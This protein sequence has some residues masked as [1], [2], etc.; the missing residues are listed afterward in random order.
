M[1]SC[2]TVFSPFLSL[3]I[4]LEEVVHKHLKPGVHMIAEVQQLIADLV[5]VVFA[6]EIN[7]LLKAIFVDQ[8]FLVLLG[9]KD[10]LYITVNKVVSYFQVVVFLFFT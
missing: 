6:H 8:R 7:K 5:A 9:N 4:D 10:S 1:V 3:S 2:N